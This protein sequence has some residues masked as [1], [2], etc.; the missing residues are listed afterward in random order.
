MRIINGATA[1][2]FTIDFGE[3]E[4][5]LIA[6]DGQD[7]EP[8][9]GR[10]FPMTM[11]QRIDVRLQLPSEPAPSRSWHCAR[12]AEKGPNHPASGQG[13]GG[14]DRDGGR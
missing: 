6:V 2:A 12:G 1:T 8:V 5:E 9:K 14:Q 3:L 13:G 4:G 11:G 7:I 10:R